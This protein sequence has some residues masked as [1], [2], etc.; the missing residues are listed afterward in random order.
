MANQD[1]FDSETHSGT[2]IETKRV[3]HLDSFSTHY[4]LQRDPDEGAKDTVTATPK[5]ANPENENELYHGLCKLC[6]CFKKKKWCPKAISRAGRSRYSGVGPERSVERLKELSG[7]VRTIIEC[8]GEDPAREGLRETPERYAKAILFFTKGYEEDARDLVN[9]AIFDE[10]NDNMVIV[11][12][13]DIF[14]LCEHHMVPFT[15]QV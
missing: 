1:S 5:R 10:K 4:R 14:S 6:R 2:S 3:A 8:I 12:N 9:G 7:A 11:Q 13:I 15:G